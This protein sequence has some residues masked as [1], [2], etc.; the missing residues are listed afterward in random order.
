MNSWQMGYNEFSFGPS[1]FL[2]PAS[3]IQENKK[4]VFQMELEEVQ[5]A[6]WKIQDNATRKEE[7]HIRVL[8]A[9]PEYRYVYTCPKCGCHVAHRCRIGHELTPDPA[10]ICI[11][12]QCVYTLTV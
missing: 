6:V 4:E 11:N 5:Q 8:S 12:C 2:N 1:V 7:G 9:W 3:K 10:A